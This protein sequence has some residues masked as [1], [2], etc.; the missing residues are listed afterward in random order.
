MITETVTEDCY[1]LPDDGIMA[2][3]RLLELVAGPGETYI[4]AYAFTLPELYGAVKAA[5][6]H[7]VPVHLLLDRSQSCGHTEA[8]MLKA[9]AEG[10][11]CG[12]VTITTAGGGSAST[13]QIYHW[14]ALV[15]LA[16]DGGA[17]WCVEGS[18]NLSASGFQQGNSFRVFRSAP[19]SDAFIANFKEHQAWARTHELQYQ[20]SARVTVCTA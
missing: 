12:D 13:G 19:W 15:I 20:I 2:K 1:F 16:T 8:P 14:K 3:A 17:P 4:S 18:T 11:K 6:A 10:L 7:G 9:L 5:D